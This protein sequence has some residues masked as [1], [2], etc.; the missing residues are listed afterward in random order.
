MTRNE[1]L[2]E[3][4]RDM[5]MRADLSQGYL[6]DRDSRGGQWLGYAVD[7]ANVMIA[8]IESGR[9]EFCHDALTETFGPYCSDCR[10][11]DE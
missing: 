11:D 3:G 9:T 6:G 7:E 8:A 4:I 2:L 1:W 5:Q 10:P